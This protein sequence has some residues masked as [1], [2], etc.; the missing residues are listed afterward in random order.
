[1]LSSVVFAIETLELPALNRE[2]RRK[3]VLAMSRFDGFTVVAGSKY[4]MADGGVLYSKDKT[5]LY[6]CPQTA[7]SDNFV[8]PAETKLIRSMAFFECQDI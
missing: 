5:T 1:M 8:V 2:N 3:A 4:M 7:K 6:E